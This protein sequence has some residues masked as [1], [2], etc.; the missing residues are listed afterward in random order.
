MTSKNRRP[1]SLLHGNLILLRDGVNTAFLL[2]LTFLL[3]LVVCSM[4]SLARTVPGEKPMLLSEHPLS[5]SLW[6]MDTAKR[7]RPEALYDA[8]SDAD[9]LLLGET[10]DNPRHHALQAQIIDEV[11][12]QGR[13]AKIVF[14]MLEPSQQ[15][16]VNAVAR[17]INHHGGSDMVNLP[18]RLAA[19]RDDLHWKDRGWP[20]WALYQP[21]FASAITHAM[22]IFAGN[23]ERADVRALGQSGKLPAHLQEDLQWDHTY[24]KAQSESLTDELVSAHCGMISRDA[25]GPMMKMQRFKD[26]HMARAMRS[27][28]QDG[29]L[30]ILVAGKG[31]TRKDRGVP[32]FLEAGAK[33]VSIGFVEVV[34]GAKK[35]SAYDAFD[36]ALYDWI[37]FTPRVDEIDPCDKFKAQLKT[38]HKGNTTQKDK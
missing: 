25:V 35:P 6:R 13:E 9:Y 1:F 12:A 33:V 20:D 3:A 38:M 8:I 5:G 4:P 30:A 31:H 27:G 10:H 17:Y 37:W 7:A 18:K 2:G 26:A 16:L 24:N 23:P 28:H 36:P 29:S 15:P 22:P 11:G 34:R 19:L 32:I 21:L 14:E